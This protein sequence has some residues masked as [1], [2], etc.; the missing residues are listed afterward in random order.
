[1]KF[2]IAGLGNPGK[3][4]QDTRHNAGALF[5]DALRKDLKFPAWKKSIKHRGELSEG[6][7]EGMALT[8]VRPATFMNLSGDSIKTFFRD[9]KTPINLLVVHDELNIPLGEIKLSYNKSPGGH[10]GVLSIASQLKTNAFLRL[11]IG[12]TP[13]ASSVFK[14]PKKDV[15]SDDFVLSNFSTGERKKLEHVFKTALS[16][17]YAL[18]TEGKEKAMTRFNA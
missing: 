1:M 7:Y 2:L 17:T 16:A 13:A 9:K 10:N 3:R 8:L 14:K 6:E 4:Y 18:L 12:I 15:V 5:L 11:R